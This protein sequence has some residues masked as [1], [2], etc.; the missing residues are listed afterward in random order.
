MSRNYETGLGI[1]GGVVHDRLLSNIQKAFQIPD[2]NF[3]LLKTVMVVR[4]GSAGSARNT[5]VVL[6]VGST[7]E[8]ILDDDDIAKVA[9]IFRS[10]KKIEWYLEHFKWA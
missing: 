9:K 2:N 10:G 1:P 4:P 6:S 5:D 8:G 7:T 3:D